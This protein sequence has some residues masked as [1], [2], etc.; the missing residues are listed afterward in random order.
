[1]QGFRGRWTA[2]A[3]VAILSAI[4]TV[5]A[6]AQQVFGS[7]YGT[8]TDAS[9]AAVANAKVTISDPAKGTSSE[10]T[11]DAAG[12]YRKG[13][14]IPDTYKITIEA[15]GFQKVVSSDI[16]V[17]VDAQARFDAALKV[18]DVTTE[19]EV[20][21]AAPLLQ[22]ASGDVAQTFTAKEVTELP[23]IGRNMQSMELLQ[24]G[25]AKMGWQHASDENPQ[26]SVQMVVDGQ[27]FS[28]MG[29]ELDG[30][31]N[32]DPI[33]G[34]IVINPTM[35]SISEVKQALQNFDAEFNYV[36]GGVASYSTKSGSNEFHGDGFEYLQLNT[37]GFVSF[38]R[39]PF[40][41]QPAATYRQN[42]FGGS[43]SGPI[44]KDKL[45]FF[46]DAQLNRQSQ[47][48]SIVTSVPTNL[49]RGGNFSDWLAYN[50]NYQIYDPRTGDL[51][52]GIGR[53]AY[54]NNMIP[55]S[56]LST[57]S[58][59][60]LAYFPQPNQQQ[61]PGAPFVNNYAVNG[62]VAITGNL[63][64]T[65]EDYY[66]NQKNT[67]FGRY[68][69]ASYT[70][71][72]PGAFG[73][74]AGGPTFVNYAG[75]SQSLNQSVA[76]GWTDTI[77]P[78]LINEFR[79]G[80]MRY[81]VF[82]TPNGYGTQPALQ[83]GIPGLNLDK[84]YTSGMPYF[85]ITSPNDAYQLGYAL[86]VNQCNCPLT[87]TESQIQFVDNATKVMGKHSFKFGADLRWARNLRVPSD[88][89]R[90]G[91]LTFNG[92][93]T[94]NVPSLGASASPGI[95]LATFLLGDVSSFQ[96]YVSTSTNAA[97]RQH[98]LFW[99]G[100]DEYRPT[101]KLTVTIGLRWEMV[102][103]ESVN[104]A[105]NGSTLDLNNGLMY[106]F[107]VGGVS[108]HGIQ[109]M[110]W[111]NFAPRLGFA[112]QIDSKTVIRG[113]YGW[114]YDLG[115]FG[116]IFGHNVT[117][118]PPVLSNQNTNP[119]N[120][121]TPVF[122]L[123]TG[124]LTLP[125]VTVSSN[126]TFPLP[127]GINPKFR[128]A[129]VTLP[130]TYQYNLAVQRQVTSKISF[131]VAYVGNSNR[132]N[133]IGTGQSIN[134]NEA[135]FVPGVSNTNLDRPYF[136]IFGWTNDLSYYCN[137]SNEHYNAAQV[138]FR[139]NN[140][141]GWGLQGSYTYQ[142]Q[143]G[144]GW[145]YDS[146]YYF[147]YGPRALGQ[148]N[149]STLPQQQWTIAQTYDIPFGHGRKY[150][151]NVNRAVDAALGGWTLS[152]VMTYY[153]GFPFDPTLENY[154]ATGG[155]PNA[156]TTNRPD[157]GA[158]NPY[159]GGTGNRIRWFQGSLGYAGTGNI[160]AAF[161]IPQPNTMGN[162][163]INVL[164]GPIFIQQ[165]LSIMKTFHIT[166]RIGFQLRTDSRNIFNHTNLGL[167]NSDLQSPSVGQITGIA[168]G[169]NMRSLQ[170]SGTIRF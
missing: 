152:G 20:T 151:A 159:A 118:N 142:N 86:G 80:W 60:I 121:F 15:P 128:P 111:H 163:P 97:E 39:N 122:T 55:A 54:Y 157:L 14:L 169:G 33:L 106:V 139:V 131:T 25:A 133:F 153:S 103:P 17:E 113:G 116:S 93:N 165:D 74:L 19:V 98:R 9:G 134:P 42:Q 11:T 62:A 164:Y 112:Y 50:P 10:V 32:Q 83:A 31:T 70:E 154:G 7:I 35:D 88:S 137:C 1:M 6:S 24:P 147:L 82:D 49:N 34:I 108:N 22:T 8:I 2:W 136:P 91:E 76:L 81:H 45:F 64:D 115:T 138:A 109:S 149:T 158:G 75:N 129:T 72:A 84:T 161:L 95:G 68:S 73:E 99:Y 63:W 4:F 71:A 77:S 148:G 59:N 144:D 102:F 92:T 170:F 168:G 126:G 69:Y 124:P 78:T 46:G 117:Q 100:Q 143:Y 27:L 18:G 58:Q 166:E 23:N 96:R 61:I 101:S 150:G 104:A 38:A 145:G 105:G 37:P 140:W 65:R 87:Q 43:I 5:S 127:L 120:N 146:N 85:N 160:S 66:I 52:T 13:Q 110:N 30:T 94:G 44:L 114:G 135:V 16:V 67:I 21:A 28:A 130:T 47:G 162:Y 56:Q 36:G 41:N 53:T 167:P 89:H 51:R 48:G 119:P 155:Q 132:H 40:S 79:F 26:G 156:G 29:Y 141:G 3:I 12:N 107:G 57:Q 90:A 125:P 123:A